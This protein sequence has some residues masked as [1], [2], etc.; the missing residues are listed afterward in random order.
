MDETFADGDLG[1]TIPQTVVKETTEGSQSALIHKGLQLSP[2][3]WRCDGA[4]G[5][6]RRVR[7]THTTSLQTTV[8]FTYP[9]FLISIHGKKTI[10]KSSCC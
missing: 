10:L 4:I 5:W 3:G 6:C 2:E 1:V 8:Y 9:D 7:D